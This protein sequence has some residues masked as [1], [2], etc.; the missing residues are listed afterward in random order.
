M[1][2]S[3]ADKPDIISK[4]KGFFM[5]KQI[6][7]FLLLGVMLLSAAVAETA[8]TPALGEREKQA[9][10][11]W[12]IA[13]VPG[14]PW[15]VLTW[16]RNTI[17]AK[18]DTY[19]VSLQDAVKEEIA[20]EVTRAHDSISAFAAHLM[21]AA[22]NR[23][24]SEEDWEEGFSYEIAN[25]FNGTF[26]KSGDMQL[27]SWFQDGDYKV[28]ITDGDT[29]RIYLCE[30]DE[31]EDGDEFVIRLI[32]IGTGDGA[33]SEQDDHGIATF[34]LNDEG[35]L[36]WQRANGENVEFTQI[37][38]PLTMFTW[39]TDS[40]YLNI[41]WYGNLD[42]RIVVDSGV[43]GIIWT[44]SCTL[45]EETNTFSGT[46]RKEVFGDLAYDDAEAS[47]VL[48]EDKTFIAWTDDHET[49]AADGL[50]FE[51]VEPAFTQTEWFAREVMAVFGYF[52]EGQYI[53]TVMMKDDTEYSYVC[54]YDR[55]TGTLRA[56]DP[57]T[58]NPEEFGEPERFKSTATFT[59][60]DEDHLI[61]RDDSGVSG[62]G[63]VLEHTND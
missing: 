55:E 33:E 32:G 26:W 41:E 54:D 27:Q 50:T 15:Q 10:I 58:L 2:S 45:N 56:V 8:E 19:D 62:E 53:M 17:L 6:V 48:S 12:L 14:E 5:K 35:N 61:W 34:Q 39:Y 22:A 57:A 40:K 60:E 37:I 9:A 49:A 47:F 11:N 20:D 30:Y 25:I 31:R 44:Y 59:L 52:T 46:G 16:D 3:A 18:L 13:Q 29:E 28:V 51:I 42:Y 7:I 1:I 4:R 23:Q 38:D 36:I 21:D 63:I 24:F 43:E